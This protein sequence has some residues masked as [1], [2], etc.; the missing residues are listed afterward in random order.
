MAKCCSCDSRKGKRNCPALGGVICSQCCGNKKEKEIACPHNCFYL[1]TSKKY[2]AERQES[3]KISNFE[4]DLKLL[5]NDENRHL[6][7]LQNIESGIHHLYKEKG[8]IRD[9]DV[10]GALEYFIETGKARFDLPSKI[11]AE[12]PPNIQAIA[13]TVEK[14]LNFRESLSGEREELMTKL[15]CIRRIL[16]SVRTH[17]NP[18]NSQSYLEFAGQFL[19]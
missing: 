14:I 12:L 15:A 1:G 4:R 13:D 16:D 3:E 8:D 7:M 19:K 18:R 5:P 9:S 11:P 10:E 2:F 17:F 6:E